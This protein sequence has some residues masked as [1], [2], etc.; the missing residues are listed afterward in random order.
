MEHKEFGPEI[1][2]A[3]MPDWLDRDEVIVGKWS[4]GWYSGISAP[5][6]CYASPGDIVAIRLR[7]DHPYYQESGDAAR[8]EPTED[9]GDYV[10]VKTMSET[11]ARALFPW[12]ALLGLRNLGIIR[13]ENLLEQFERDNPEYPLI[14]DEEKSAVKRAIE[15]MESRNA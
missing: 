9:D 11:E 14:T 4:H 2:V 5:V 13:E 6:D 10:R 7:A 3:G 8:T 12:D 1:A 15:W